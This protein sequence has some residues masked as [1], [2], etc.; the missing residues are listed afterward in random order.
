MNGLKISKMQVINNPKEDAKIPIVQNGTNYSMPFGTLSKLLIQIYENSDIL[1]QVSDAATEVACRLKAL[2]D[3]ENNMSAA[4]E[5]REASVHNAL[6][7]IAEASG[8][9]DAATASA[10]S[11]AQSANTAAS[12]AETSANNANSAIAS[13]ISDNVLSAFE[14]PS[15]RSRWNDI[16]NEKSGITSQ[17][18]TYGIS[19]E[20]TNYNNAFQSL[21]TYLNNGTTWS[22]GVPIWL[23]DANLSTDTVIV[24]STYRTN[25]NNYFS[26]RQILLNAIY[27]KAKTLADAA[28][29]QANMATTNAAAAQ[30]TANTAD[31]NATIALNH[32]SDLVS[33]NI[34]SAVK[35]P[36]QLTEWEQAVS[37]KSLYDSEAIT[38]NISTEKTDYDN[39]FIALANYLNGDTTWA[40]G[41]TPLWFQDLSTNTTIVGDTYRSTWLSYYK[42]RGLLLNKITAQAK[43]IAENNSKNYIDA[44]VIVPCGNWEPGTS[45]PKNRLVIFNNQPFISTTNTSDCP[46][47]VLADENGDYL[48]DDGNYI[49]PTDENGNITYNPSWKAYSSSEALEQDIA[50]FKKETSA[51][52][53]I[54]ND[55]INSI[56]IRVNKLLG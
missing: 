32:I 46:I 52:L 25:W 51:T 38:Y 14:K 16:A 17:A 8:K 42:S 33:D 4:E 26:T 1:K 24:G 27:A 30:A 31:T 10:N 50:K 23:A 39:A 55:E 12:N 13:I 11:A 54:L 53:K 21:A 2:T 5:Q 37:D 29:T 20:L 34:L 6:E 35:K 15:E 49:T 7:D 41:T 48:V 45:Y 9:A 22:T 56:L 44:S 18:N 36:A 40:S 28:Q 19:T 3:A 47:V 43:V